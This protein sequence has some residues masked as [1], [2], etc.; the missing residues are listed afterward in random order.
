MDEWRSLTLDDVHDDGPN[1][2]VRTAGRRAKRCSSEARPPRPCG[3]CYARSLRKGAIGY[4]VAHED[5]FDRVVVLGGY[6]LRSA[7]CTDL[8]SAVLAA[9][10]IMRSIERCEGND[11]APANEKRPGA[12]EGEGDTE[13][14][15]Q[16]YA[17]I[18]NEN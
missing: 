5:L 7:L 9:L 2:R 17:V 11:A 12:W 13:P 16:I 4:A 1:C 3:R 14:L 18:L 15:E 6:S 10:T 8:G